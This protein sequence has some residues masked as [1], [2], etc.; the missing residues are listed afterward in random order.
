MKLDNGESTANSGSHL[1]WIRCFGA[2]GR[3]E[4]RAIPNIADLDSFVDVGCLIARGCVERAWV[5]GSTQV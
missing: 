5:W 2:T 1:Y 3:I 4:I